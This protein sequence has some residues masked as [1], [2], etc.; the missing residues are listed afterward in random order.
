MMLGDVDEHERMRNRRCEAKENEKKL[1]KLRAQ[2]GPAAPAR[3]EDVHRPA[4]NDV[5][6]A[7]RKEQTSHHKFQQKHSLATTAIYGLKIV[8]Q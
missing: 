6:Q 1:S 8:T 3:L 2:P 4:N 7:Q 5:S